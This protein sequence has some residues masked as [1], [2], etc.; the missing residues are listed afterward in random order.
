MRYVKKRVSGICPETEDSQSI[1]ITFAEV[2]MLGNPTIGYKAMKYRC[3]Y[4]DN[5]GCS[6]NGPDGSNCPL[7]KAGQD[8][9]G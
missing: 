7:F 3:T 5:Y 1:E 4:C 8:W 9:T 2:R 6:S